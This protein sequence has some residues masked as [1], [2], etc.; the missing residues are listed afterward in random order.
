MINETWETY[1][2]SAVK[3]LR[4]SMGSVIMVKIPASSILQAQDITNL[5]GLTYPAI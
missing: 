1:R 4:I 3:H 5:E 2:G